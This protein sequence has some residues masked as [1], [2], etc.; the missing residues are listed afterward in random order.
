MIDVLNA[1]TP[2]ANVAEDAAPFYMSC[3]V[4][5]VV[6]LLEREAGSSFTRVGS[7]P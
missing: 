3:R 6:A 7:L 2:S 5:D 4:V 1:G